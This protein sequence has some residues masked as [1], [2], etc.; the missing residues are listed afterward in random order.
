MVLMGDLFRDYRINYEKK[1]KASLGPH[2]LDTEQ[3][4]VCVCERERECLPA[5]SVWANKSEPLSNPT[6]ASVYSVCGN[7]MVC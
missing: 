2:N 6:I 7:A 5:C 4:C 1:R 3:W